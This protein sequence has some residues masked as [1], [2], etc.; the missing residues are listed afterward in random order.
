MGQSAEKTGQTKS[1]ARVT[2]Y[3]GQLLRLN[4]NA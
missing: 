2:H 1:Q 3:G 4:L